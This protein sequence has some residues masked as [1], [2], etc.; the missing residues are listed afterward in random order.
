MTGEASAEAAAKAVLSRPGAKTEWCVVKQGGEGALLAC[1][2]SGAVHHA[3]GMKVRGAWVHW[4]ASRQ[5]LHAKCGASKGEAQAQ[6][7]QGRSWGN[8]RCRGSQVT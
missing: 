6:L 1:K 8:R 7:L 5:R 4:E 3:P 2:S